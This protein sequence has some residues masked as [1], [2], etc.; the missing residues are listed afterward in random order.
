[1][2]DVIDLLQGQYPRLPGTA[3]DETVI[4]LV[5]ALIGEQNMQA[6]EFHKIILFF[7]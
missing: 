6:I 5:R 1:M 4:A 2:E 3:P 7:L